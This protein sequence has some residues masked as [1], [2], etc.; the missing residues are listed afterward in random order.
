MDL[1]ERYDHSG[2][3]GLGDPEL[4]ALILGHGIAG[5]SALWLAVELMERFGGLQGLARTH[6]REY[7]A[8]KGL[9]PAQ[10]VKIHAALTLGQRSLVS[11][12]RGP[13]ILRA[14]DAARVLM[15]GLAH[16]QDEELHALF[17]DRRHQVLGLGRL[18][19]G[20]DSCVLV[21]SRQIYREAMRRGAAALI[22][23]HNHPSG[24]PEPSKDDR[25]VTRTVAQAGRQLGIQLL[26]HL[27]FGG[28][29]WVSLAERGE[30]PAW[31]PM[32]VARVA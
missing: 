7:L 11:P 26:D 5:R 28:P 30:L 21:D 9:G 31:E 1:R 20:T 32:P 12:P 4:L 15:P 8:I 17:V 19:K 25:E 23:A 14:G 3:D 6:P 24:D 18:A 27:V 2:P 29:R 22:L 16:G 10:A 13:Q